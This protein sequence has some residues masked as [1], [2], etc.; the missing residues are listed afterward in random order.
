MLSVEVERGPGLRV[1]RAWTM[2]DD[3]ATLSEARI[4]NEAVVGLA[5]PPSRSDRGTPIHAPY[6]LVT[7]A[8]DGSSCTNETLDV[9]TD[10]L[11]G[12]VHNPSRPTAPTTQAEPDV[13]VN[14]SEEHT[15]DIQSL[16]R[17]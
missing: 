16:M 11:G 14:R 3:V 12:V 2:P 6:E 10:Q 15:H 1:E 13:D 17:R 5:T 9:S 7:C 4:V 8:I